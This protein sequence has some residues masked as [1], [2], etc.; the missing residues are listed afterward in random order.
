MITT[1]TTIPSTARRAEPSSFAAKNF[2]YM[3]LSPSSRKKVGKKTPKAQTGPCAPN[4]AKCVAGTV[5]TTCS[6]PP[7]AESASGRASRTPTIMSRPLKMSIE[8]IETMPA[9]SVKTITSTQASSRPCSTEICGRPPGRS[10]V[11]R[12][13]SRPAPRNW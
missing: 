1:P 12:F 9:S 13:I 6:R 11:T 10:C 7:A 3:L 8:T 5:A 2:W 4:G